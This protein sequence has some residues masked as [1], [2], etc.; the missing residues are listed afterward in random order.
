[1]KPNLLYASYQ[2]II[3]GEGD[4]KTVKHLYTALVHRNIAPPADPRILAASDEERAAYQLEMIREAAQQDWS[5]FVVVMHEV[6]GSDGYIGSGRR[7]QRI[8]GNR[9]QAQR[10]SA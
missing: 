7:N 10:A 9:Q 8:N 3:A 6:V 5:A 2:H 1:M 4:A